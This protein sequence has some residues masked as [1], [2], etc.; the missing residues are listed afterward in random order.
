MVKAVF[1]GETLAESDKT[2]IVEGNHYFPRSS[3]KKGI[4]TKSKTPYTCHW[5]GEAQYWNVKVNEKIMKDLA[6][7]YPNPK[8]AAKNIK[9]YIS[10]DP[11]V[12]ISK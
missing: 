8:P 5:K 11:K 6:W 12:N 2:E 10:F 9:E 7:S 3:V 1:K 4:L